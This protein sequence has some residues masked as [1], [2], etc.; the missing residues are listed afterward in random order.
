MPSVYLCSPTNSTLFTTCCD[1]AITDW[2]D[3]CQSCNQT[4]EPRSWDSAYGP[5]R[6]RVR[7]YGNYRTNDGRT[8]ECIAGRKARGTS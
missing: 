8:P 1:T 4:I 5:I 7:G 2:Q 3:K 6:Q